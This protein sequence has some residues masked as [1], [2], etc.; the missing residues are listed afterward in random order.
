MSFTCDVNRVWDELYRACPFLNDYLPWAFAKAVP[1]CALHFCHDPYARALPR[2]SAPAVLRAFVR[3]L[4]CTVAVPP[5]DE[6]AD[7]AAENTYVDVYET[8]QHDS[9]CEHTPFAE[10]VGHDA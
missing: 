3:V 4:P 6:C 5:A 7:S 10:A 8:T 9:D 2:A 1:A